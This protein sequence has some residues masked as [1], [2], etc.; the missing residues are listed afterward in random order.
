MT[1]IEIVG[2]SSI[3]I[4]EVMKILADALKQEPA[5][6]P[7]ELRAKL[8][9]ILEGRTDAWVDELRMAADAAFAKP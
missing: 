5:P 4:Q 6:T 9:L 1:P 3:V 7:A 8:L 2:F